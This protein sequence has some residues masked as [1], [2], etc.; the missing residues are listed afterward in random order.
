[1]QTK[2]NICITAGEQLVSDDNY[3]RTCLRRCVK[4]LH[5]KLCAFIVTTISCNGNSNQTVS[6][7]DTIPVPQE[8]RLKART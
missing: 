6:N 3:C 8:H 2:H 7:K 1:M 4:S 5:D